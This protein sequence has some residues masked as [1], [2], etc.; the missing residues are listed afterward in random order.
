MDIHEKAYVSPGADVAEYCF[1][2][3]FTVV[4]A[5]AS[6]G[7][8]TR[9]GAGCHVQGDVRIGKNCEIGS[10]CLL[11]RQLQVMDGAIFGANVTTVGQVRVAPGVQ[12]GAGSVLMGDSRPLSILKNVHPGSIVTWSSE[13]GAKRQK[14][15]VE[16]VE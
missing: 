8:S 9:I 5:G 2:G 7:E 16:E 3:P 4:D 1:I 14:K 10:G 6:I 13:S 15:E 12:V 11:G